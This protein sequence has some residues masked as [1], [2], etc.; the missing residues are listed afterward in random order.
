MEGVRIEEPEVV[1]PSRWVGGGREDA[2]IPAAT[3]EPVGPNE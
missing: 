1:T 3:G 2:H